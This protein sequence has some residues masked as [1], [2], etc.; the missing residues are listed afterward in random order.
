MEKLAQL[1]ARIYEKHVP[2]LDE[3]FRAN[4]FIRV[5]CSPPGDPRAFPLLE[6]LDLRNMILTMYMVKHLRG[7]TILEAGHNNDTFDLLSLAR[8]LI[9][10][11]VSVDGSFMRV[12]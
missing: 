8:S 6:G 7:N 5:Q 1:A 11:E 9:K 2:Q 10:K 4:R 3:Y 12:E